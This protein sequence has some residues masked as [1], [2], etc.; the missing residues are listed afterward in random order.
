MTLLDQ[1]SDALGASGAL[2]DLSSSLGTSAADTDSLLGAGLPAI[3]GGLGAQSGGDGV[4]AMMGLLGDDGGD[5]VGSLGSFF[6]QGDKTGLASKLVGSLFGSQRSAIESHVASGSGAAMSVVSRL[7]P[8]LAPAVLGFISKMVKDDGI[9]ADGLGEK[10]A[11]IGADGPLGDILAKNAEEDESGFVTGLAALRDAGGLG[12]LIP[13]ASAAAPVAAAA[14]AGGAGAVTA[15]AAPQDDED[16]NGLGWTAIVLPIIAL[17]AGLV[18]WQCGT[19]DDSHG[20]D[21]DHSA[22]VEVAAEAEA[23]PEPTAEPEP[24]PTAVPE[25]T[26]APEPEPTA[27]PEP[28]PEPVVTLADLAVGTPELSTLVGIATD[29]GLAGQLADPDAGP[30]TIFAPTNDAFASA[31]GLLARLDGDQ[32]ATT[33]TYH[34]VPGVVMAADLVPGATFDTLAGE[35]LTVGADGTLTGGISVA[36]ADITAANGVVHIIEQVLVPGSVSRSLV[37]QDVNAAFELNPIQFSLGSADILPESQVT[38]DEAIVT[39]TSLPAGAIFEVQG[40]TDSQGD[41]ASNQTLSEARAASVVAYLVA[42]GVDADMLVPRGYGETT[43]KVDP[44]ESPEDF[45]ANRR[46]EFVDISN[47]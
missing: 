38:L 3:L 36:T 47:G 17:I 31:D 8:M 42:G 10:L 21:G 25:P 9:D 4:G 13:A 41:D 11:A 43:L 5:F 16:R 19:S 37:A 29:L 2:G 6:A 28:T 18:L 40:H 22:E 7:L 30:F 23:E 39:L 1:I 44:E 46:I 34:V 20:D 45:A 14:A 35:T 15:L 24:E 32:T 26:A 33:V 27:T 12:A